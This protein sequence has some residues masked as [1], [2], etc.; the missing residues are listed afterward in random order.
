MLALGASTLAPWLAYI[1]AADF[2]METYPESNLMFVF[3]TFRVSDPETRA[4]VETAQR[5]IIV[6]SCALVVTGMTY[7]LPSFLASMSGGG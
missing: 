1:A 5:A 4:V 2:F 6:L 3:P 7:T